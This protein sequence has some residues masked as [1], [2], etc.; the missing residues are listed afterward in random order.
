MLRDKEH[1]EKEAILARL[2][3]MVHAQGLD[4]LFCDVVELAQHILPFLSPCGLY[5]AFTAMP[6]RFQSLNISV[7]SMF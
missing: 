6:T 3:Q 1:E 7:I 5:A 4:P 2:S